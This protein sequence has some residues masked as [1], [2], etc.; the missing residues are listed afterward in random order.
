MTVLQRNVAGS[1]V[2]LAL[3][4]DHLRKKA[5]SRKNPNGTILYVDT[6]T[7]C[8]FA[9]IYLARM[10]NQF[11]QLFNCAKSARERRQIFNWLHTVLQKKGE[12]LLR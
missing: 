10:Y 3:F 6:Q 7:D 5:M 1:G 12:E 8:F 11:N 9:S 2:L 4:D